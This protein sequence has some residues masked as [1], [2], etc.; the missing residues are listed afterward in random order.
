MKNND[1]WEKR[2]RRYWIS[3]NSVSKIFMRLYYKLEGLIW[4]GICVGICVVVFKFVFFL[5]F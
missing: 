2:R 5:G 3:N 1:E 4:L